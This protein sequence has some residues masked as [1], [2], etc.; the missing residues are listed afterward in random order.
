MPHGGLV[1]RRLGDAGAYEQRW[2]SRA[3]SRA[4]GRGCH[5]EAMAGGLRE[6]RGVGGVLVTVVGGLGAIRGG[7]VGRMV[8][9]LILHPSHRSIYL[10]V[11]VNGD[12]M[13]YPPI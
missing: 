5:L 9:V 2:S 4:A 6:A 1:V 7:G 12:D 10:V 3:D 13:R 11:A 8:G